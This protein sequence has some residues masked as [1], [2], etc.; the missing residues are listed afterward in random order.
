MTSCPKR[1]N[2]SP[3]FTTVNPVTQLALVAVNRASVRESV[4]PFTA[5]FVESSTVPIDMSMLKLI[6]RVMGGYRI[7]GVNLC[8]S[9]LYFTT[10]MIQ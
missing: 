1:V 9:F 3:V 2:L 4:S 6:I 7:I 8:K 10:K 5:A